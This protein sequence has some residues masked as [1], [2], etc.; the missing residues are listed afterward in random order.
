MPVPDSLHELV[1]GRLLALPAESRDFLIAA[2]AHAHPTIAITEAATG[3]GRAVGLQ[4]A[5]EARIVESERDRIRFTHPLL[6]AGV[7]ETADPVRR[8]EIHARLAELLEDPEARAWQL[9]ASVDEPNAVVA[10]A[11]EHAAQHA[12]GRG[13]LRPAALLLDRAREL[14][15]PERRDDAVRRAVDAAYL[16]FE[17]GDSPRA[18][19]QLREVI[20]TLPPSDERARAL[21]VLARVRTYKAPGDAVDL[22]LQLVDEAEGHPELLALAHEGVAS[23]L[24]WLLERFEEQVEHADATLTFANQRGD[25]AL[26]GDALVSKL[27]AEAWLGRTSATTVEAALALQDSTADRRLLDQPLVAVVHCWLWADQPESARDALIE[28][29]RR[30]REIGDESSRPY[31]LSLLGYVEYILGNGQSALDCAREGQEAAEQSGQPLFTSYHLALD[32]LVEGHPEHAREAMRRAVA[33]VPTTG[34]EGGLL[35]SSAAGHLELALGNPEQATAV[36]EP[37]A[38]RVIREG[39]AE[40]NA[41]RFVVD[42]VEALI[43]LGRRDEAA[44]LL[45]W[46]EGNARRLE[47]AS[48]L[49]NCARCRGLLAAQAGDLDAALA[50][51]QEALEWHAKVEL[52]LDRGRTLLA[53][54]AAQRRAKRRREAR[55]TLEE[56]LAV[57][58]RIGSELWADRA[59]AELR[60]IS[61]RASSS[62]ALTPAEERIAALVAEGKTNREVAAALFLSERT[63]EGHLSH[64]F[65]KL[66]VRSRTEL[67]RKLASRD[68]LRGSPRQTQGIPPFRTR[69]PRSSLDSGGYEGHQE[70]KEEEP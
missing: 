65:G 35:A 44:D 66:G 28:M 26:A 37:L 22:F 54:G 33:L 42:Q 64:V 2:A 27:L 20:D 7:L 16:H 18:E 19:A 47:R 38:E 13:G 29:L 56:A 53:L 5:L 60:R 70:Q 50:A 68:Q 34:G 15:P 4:P 21:W 45:D 36:L 51:Y 62:G 39:I 40:P 17:S 49:A 30:A 1:H 14:T 12:R 55:E 46:Y 24:L 9:A 43:E 10:G 67:A 32:S 59:R 6:A 8:A 31:V 52:P 25:D 63:V 69:P 3:V 61:G 57:F 23:S 41:V 58:E 11:L 48:A